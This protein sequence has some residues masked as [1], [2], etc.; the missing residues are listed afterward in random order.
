MVTVAAVVQQSDGELSVQR[1]AVSRAQQEDF[2]RRLD[3]QSRVL[4]VGLESRRHTLADT[5]RNEQWG[6]NRMDIDKLRSLGTGRG[7]TVAVVDTGVDAT[8]PDLSHAVLPGVDLVDSTGDG[9]TDPNGHG[10]H[11]AGIIAAAVNGVGVEGLAP[12][13]SI[14]PVRVLGRDGSG[15]DAVIAQ[16][17]LWAVRNG[18]QVIN[19]SLGG[20]DLDPLLADAVDQAISAGVLVVAA[21]G[22]SGNSGDTMYPAAHPAVVAV[23][24]TGPDDRT[25]P[26]ST[27]GDYVDIAAPGTMILST[28]PAN[29]YRFESGTSMA[30]PFVAAAAAV[31]LE[32]SLTPSQVVSRLFAS[33]FDTD[34]EG[35]DR[36]SGNGIVDPVAAATTGTPRTDQPKPVISP[37]IPV[38]PPVEL[39]QLPELT[40][41]ILPPLPELARP[42]LPD[43][44]PLPL[45]QLPARPRPTPVVPI[46]PVEGVRRLSPLE[47]SLDLE[48]RRTAGQ[49]RVTLML[50]TRQFALA[51]REVSISLS[52][53]N[54]TVRRLVRT[55]ATGRAVLAVKTSSA[56]SVHASW[57]GDGVTA[58]VRRSADVSG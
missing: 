22:N 21:A 35:F 51:Y 4:A 26:Y 40:R 41:P 16:G 5:R 19:L 30:A 49:I 15:P 7:I 23:A 24:A 12:N 46:E 54:G 42:S 31:L 11:V 8:H 34:N 18:A 55:D 17:I 47:T 50:R 25:A 53:S 28:S 57:A 14:L 48:A 6:H 37:S 2:V 3:D 39:P 56:R 43:T 44:N 33:A 13:V 36:L 9:R 45:P 52:S 29:S 32:R 1:W 10:T 20:T 58:P 27:R 38:L